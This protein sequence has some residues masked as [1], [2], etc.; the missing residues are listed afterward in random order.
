MLLYI[1]KINNYVKVQECETV[2]KIHASRMYYV[3]RSSIITYM[4]VGIHSYKYYVHVHVHV[5]SKKSGNG[6]DQQG[7]FPRR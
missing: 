7:P 1:L 4:C 5:A 3:L 6:T 2:L